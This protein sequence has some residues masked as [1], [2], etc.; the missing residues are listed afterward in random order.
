MYAFLSQRIQTNTKN[1]TSD[2]A[3]TRATSSFVIHIIFLFRNIFSFSN[4]I[5]ISF[6]YLTHSF[7]FARNSF[8]SERSLNGQDF[9]PP[10]FSLPELFRRT[11]VHLSPTVLGSS[12]RVYLQCPLIGHIF[13][14]N[15][16]QLDRLL[17]PI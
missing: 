6:K 16:T 4:D 15:R 10:H 1:L 9:C 7:L 8:R 12:I 5:Q 3:F 13:L 14:S 17:R 11:L 2:F